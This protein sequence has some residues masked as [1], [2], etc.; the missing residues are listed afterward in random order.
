[1]SYPLKTRYLVPAIEITALAVGYLMRAGRSSVYVIFAWE[2]DSAGASAVVTADKL[3]AD[4][5]DYR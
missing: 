5:L 1:M 3:M 2:A 4:G